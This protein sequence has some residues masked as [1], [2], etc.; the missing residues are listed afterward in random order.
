MRNRVGKALLCQASISGADNCLCTTGDLEL[1][2]NCGNVVTHRFGAQ[3]QFFR[4][5]RV[6]LTL[7]NQGEHLTF[8]LCQFRKDR[9]YCLL[10][11]REV[12]DRS[13][14]R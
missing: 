14:P 10:Q 7:S 11:R 1:A 8:P 4:D 9:E 2:E 3:D 6:G 13:A 5:R 12:M